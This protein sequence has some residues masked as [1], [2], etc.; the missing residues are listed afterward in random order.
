MMVRFINQAAT[1]FAVFIVAQ[2]SASFGQNHDRRN[3][4]I[5]LWPIYVSIWF[6]LATSLTIVSARDIEYCSNMNTADNDATQNDFQ[7]NGL[8]Y[9]QCKNSYA[10]AIVQ[11][12]SCW[13]SNYAPSSDSSGCDESCPG[14]PADMCGN[15]EKA[16]Y[17]YMTLLKS[18]SGTKVSS[19]ESMTTTRGTTSDPN[20]ITTTKL[21]VT[22]TSRLSDSTTLTTKTTP[23]PRIT[24]ITRVDGYKTITIS[25]SE[26]STPTD[27]PISVST[28]SDSFFS[29]TGRAVGLCVGLALLLLAIVGAFLLWRRRRNKHREALYS[30]AESPNSTA[31]GPVGRRRSRSLSTLGLIGE[32][33]LPPIN[34]SAIDSQNFA[35]SSAGAASVPTAGAVTPKVGQVFDQRL[36]PGQLFMR[37]DHDTG[38]SRMSVRSL[39]DDTDYSRRVLRLANPDD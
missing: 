15:T 38:S 5:S 7:S 39:R 1:P 23:K 37:F 28:G 34:T 3:F 8:C 29:N 18:P 30:Q 26:T 14:Y 25:P 32:K 24:V 17:G 2:C 33:S 35:N 16:L 21:S 20:K 31:A 11:G 4:T 36:D 12:N 6:L 13:C 10:F 27:T 9:D 22:S 19:A